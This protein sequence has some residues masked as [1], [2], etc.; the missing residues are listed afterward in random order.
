MNWQWLYIIEAL[1]AIVL[2]FLT[3]KVLTD[4]PEQA[5]WLDTEERAWLA[6]HSR[7]SAQT[8]DHAQ[9]GGSEGGGVWAALCDPRVLG[10]S[11]VY[12]GT[13]AGLYV[14]G[15]CRRSS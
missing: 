12:G 4:K 14:L 1:P 6:R 3:L 13:S 2:G 10:L 9:Q 7:R 5:R 15:L 8:A 11:L